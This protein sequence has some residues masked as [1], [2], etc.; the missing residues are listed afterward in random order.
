MTLSIDKT[1]ATS[2]GMAVACV[3][4]GAGDPPP[5]TV[6]P[7]RRLVE[8]FRRE[9]DRQIISELQQTIALQEARISILQGQLEALRRGTEVTQ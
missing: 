4:P 8:G 3:A 6:A 1:A 7:D 5:G 2:P 9:R